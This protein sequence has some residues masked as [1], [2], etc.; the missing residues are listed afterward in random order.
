MRRAQA[1]AKYRLTL[2]TG[3]NCLDK[4]SLLPT[5]IHAGNPSERRFFLTAHSKVSTYSIGDLLADPEPKTDVLT[6]LGYQLHHS[7]AF[8]NP[9]GGSFRPLKKKLGPSP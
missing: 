6:G 4:L 9:S 1:A 3:A 8:V 2:H 7:M 5:L